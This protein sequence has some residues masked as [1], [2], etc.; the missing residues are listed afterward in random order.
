MFG[1]EVDISMKNLIKNFTIIF[2]LFLVVAALFSMTGGSLEEPKRIGMETLI[3]QINNEQIES[4]AV[5]GVKVDIALKSGEKETMRKEEGESFSQ[6]LNNYGVDKNKVANIKID[7]KGNEGVGFW[8]TTVIPFV[9]P[10]LIIGVFIYFMMRSVQGANSRAMMFGQSQAKEFGNDKKDKITFK[11]VAGVKE[12]KEELKEVV[13]F[14]QHPKKFL[15]LG[16]RIPRGVFSLVALEQEKLCWLERL[17]EKRMCHFSIFPVQNLWK[18]L[19]V[20]VLSR[21]RFV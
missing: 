17:L 18:C 20:S 6:L 8:M 1:E 4:I 7:I 16:A 15:D 11:D 5:E 2:L 9:L 10:F 21:A 14:L 12:A 19:W 3:A 13:E